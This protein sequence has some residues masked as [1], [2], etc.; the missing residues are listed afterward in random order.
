MARSE[1]YA[2][3]SSSI[4]TRGSFSFPDPSLPG[5]YL[6]F[7]TVV[8]ESNRLTRKEP[9]GKSD[10]GDMVRATLPPISKSCGLLRGP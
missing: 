2:S 10:M 5:D 7:L 6:A 9:F 4:Q 3:D 1:T 8:L